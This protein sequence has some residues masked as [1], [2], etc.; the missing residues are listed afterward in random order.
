MSD[1]TFIKNIYRDLLTT[2]DIED[3]KKFKQFHNETKIIGTHSGKFHVDD[4]ISTIFLS[5]IKENIILLRISTIDNNCGGILGGISDGDDIVI[6]A[7]IKPVPS[8]LKEQ[9]TV[10][11]DGNETTLTIKGRHDKYLPPRIAPVLE[12]MTALTLADALLMN[13]TSRIEYISKIYK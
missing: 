6:K 3:F 7:Y 11:K 4:V 2:E 10:D 1:N 8:I 9:R 5:K 12:A 13:M